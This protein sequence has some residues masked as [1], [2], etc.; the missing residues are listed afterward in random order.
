MPISCKHSVEIIGIQPLSAMHHLK[1]VLS[2]LTAVTAAASTAA[3]ANLS[4]LSAGTAQYDGGA[5]NTG[6]AS[7]ATAPTPI[8]SQTLSAGFTFNVEFTPGAG[9]MS[10]TVLLGELGGTANGW[11]MF[12]YNGELIF[13]TKQNSSDQYYPDSLGDLSLMP[14][15]VTHGEAAVLS[16]FGALSV[17]LT[18][19]A[20]VSWD[21]A[22]HLQLAVQEGT[23]SGAKDDFTLTGVFGNWQGDR[24]FS[25]G[26]SPRASAG[27]VGGSVGGLAGE[28]P[29]A[30]PPAPWNVEDDSENPILK[31]FSGDIV[32]A[33]YWNEAG[34][35]T[36][37]AVPEPRAGAIL[38]LGLASFLFRIRWQRKR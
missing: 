9:D 22:G 30:N 18:Y 27:G 5:I 1:T 12:L 4:D 3:A 37:T 31:S 21:Q 14:D 38:A 2:T 35:L 6:N 11:G 33:L 15:A 28:N 25:V 10:G 19:S 32:N 16:T 36:V 13:S 24:S 17:G 26:Q 7:H 23:S 29:G 20:A 8:P 34:N